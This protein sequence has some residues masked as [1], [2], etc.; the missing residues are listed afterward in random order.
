MPQHELV[1]HPGRTGP[2]R[3]ESEVL[4]NCASSGDKW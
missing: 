3:G 1:D 4:D 2:E